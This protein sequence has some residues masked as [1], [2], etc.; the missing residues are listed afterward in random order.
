MLRIHQIKL[1]LEAT[2]QELREAAAK[3]LKISQQQIQQIKLV[4]KAVDARKKDTIQL[5][6]TIDVTVQGNENQL[7]KKLKKPSVI[8]SPRQCYGPPV[9]ERPGTYP[10][11][12]VGMGPAGLLAAFILAE[13]GCCPIVIERGQ[14]VEQRS[15]AVARFWQ[16]GLL[17]PQSNVQFGE[18]GAGT[19]SDGKLTTNTKDIRHQKVLQ[20]FVETGAPEEILYAAK[21]HIGTDLLS[22]MVSGIRKKICQM[23]GQVFFETQVTDILPVTDKN[24]NPRLAGL[25][26]THQQAKRQI[27]TEDVILAIGHSA[28]DTFACLHRHNI[29]MLQKPFAIGARIEHAQDQIDRRQYGGFAGHPALGAADYKLF[30]HLPNGRSVYTFCMCPGGYVVAAA[31][32]AGGIVTNGMSRHKRNGANANSALLV[33]ITPEDFGSSHPLAGMY[34]QRQI[35]AAAFAY[36]GN[37]YFA[38]GQLVGDFLQDVDS[39]GPGLILPTYEPGIAWGKIDCC[40]PSFVTESMRAGLLEL[41]KKMPGFAAPDAVLTAPETRSSSPVRIPRDE[42]CQSIA[43]LY[44]CGEGPGYAGGIMSAA[45]DG[46]RCAEAVIEKWNKFNQ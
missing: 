28:R 6:Y 14:A 38:P 32:E 11:V 29:P 21:P 46:I 16:T 39:A 22:G 36:G 43:G 9:L 8:K 3:A 12:V 30:C 27:A 17:D 26:V 1:P 7:L 37:R 4:K 35:E 23:G 5:I 2:G 13:A 33:G 42:S 40:L 10:P 41:D 34:L 15:Q 25:E 18:G 31:S 24:G 19:F 44:P 20:T 45:T